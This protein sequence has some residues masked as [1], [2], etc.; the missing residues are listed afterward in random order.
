MR[1]LTSTL[2]AAQRAPVKEEVVVC[3][4]LDAPVERPSWRWRALYASADPDGSHGVV[5]LHA[6]PLVRARQTPTGAVYVQRLT[7]P[8]D[9]SG[10]SAWTLLEAAGSTAVGAGIAL[11]S[12]DTADALRL[13][14]VDA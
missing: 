14:R 5:Q 12:D 11:A 1:P 8:D 2:L 7:N 13:F 3:R 9:P 10:W 4:L 6:G